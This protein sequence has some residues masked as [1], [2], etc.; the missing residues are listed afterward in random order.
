MKKKTIVLGISIL[1][2][3]TILSGCTESTKDKLV[4]TW[5]GRG[6][7]SGE[8]IFRSDGTGSIISYV[9]DEIISMEYDIVNDT[10]LEI[11]FTQNDVTS[12]NDMEYEFISEDILS[13]TTNSGGM[14]DTEIF[15]RVK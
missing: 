13:L 14:T 11:T 4:G 5:Q 3:V 15:D 2:I 12:S 10:T 7:N 8:V 9:T 6:A 1:F